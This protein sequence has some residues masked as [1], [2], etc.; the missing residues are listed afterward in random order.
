MV[1]PRYPTALAL[2]ASGQ[3]DLKPL[4]SRVFPLAEANAAFEYF[5]T[6]EP[7]KVIIQPQAAPAAASS[8]L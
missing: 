2:V 3:V 4:L 5:A 7:I 8:S 6:G 1:V